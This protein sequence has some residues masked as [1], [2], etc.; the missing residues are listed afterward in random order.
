MHF[1]RASSITLAHC[2]NTCTTIVTMRLSGKSIVYQCLAIDSSDCKLHSHLLLHLFWCLR[3]QELQLVRHACCR[4]TADDEQARHG[5]AHCIIQ[6]TV[7]EKVEVGLPDA[8]PYLPPALYNIFT[9]L[10]FLFLSFPPKVEAGS[11]VEY[12]H[13]GAGVHVERDCVVSC[14]QLPAAATVPAG[15]FI[16]TIFIGSG[17]ALAAFVGRLL[18][19]VPADTVGLRRPKLS[20][21]LGFLCPG[22]HEDVKKSVKPEAAGAE[23]TLMGVPLKTALSRLSLTVEDLWPGQVRI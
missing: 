15:T 19:V 23:L 7:E 10:N 13:L 4:F 20:C 5:Q 1:P 18:R 22:V 14:C 8:V 16:H 9:H 17:Q 3:R 21:P 2:R 12:S 6:S 11:V